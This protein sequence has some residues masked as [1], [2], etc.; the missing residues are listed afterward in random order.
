MAFDGV[1]KLLRLGFVVDAG[2]RFPSLR[3]IHKS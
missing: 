2:F 3:E 1:Y